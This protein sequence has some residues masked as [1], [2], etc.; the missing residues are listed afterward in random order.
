[1]QRNTWFG[2][3]ASE[4]STE[5]VE[6]SPVRPRASVWMNPIAP[7][8]IKE[9]RNIPNPQTPIP[10]RASARP[11]NVRPRY[12]RNYAMPPESDVTRVPTMPEPTIWQYD[13][14][15]FEAESSLS[16]LSLAHSEAI[17]SRPLA[18]QV[19]LPPPRTH[20]ID[21]LDTQPPPP[22]TAIDE[23]DTRPPA[24][25]RSFAEY[26][27]VPRPR[28]IDELDT[29]PPPS[30][31]NTLIVQKSPV[32]ADKKNISSTHSLREITPFSHT[33]ANMR[34]TPTVIE[35]MLE[36]RLEEAVSWTT[37]V[38]KDSPRARR[39]ASR[40]KEY[41]GQRKS[42]LSLNPVDRVR[43][44]LLYPGRIEFLLWL[45]GTIILFIITCLLLFATV[46][47]VGWLHLGASVSGTQIAAG[48]GPPSS[49]QTPCASDN[50]TN[51]YCHQTTVSSSGLQL[52]LIDNALL[53]PTTP[54]LLH[55][56]GFS[57]NVPV[58]L[59]YDAHQPC[60]PNAT[61]AD[62]HGIFTVSL[63]LGANVS[64][65]T[66]R[67]TAYDTGSKRS[68]E[69]T[70]SIASATNAKSTPSTPTHPSSGATPPA[71]G[72]GSVGGG[73]GSNPTPISQTPVPVKPTVGI[74]PT[75]VVTQ[76]PTPTVSATP[77][78]T[79]G[80]TP[81]IGTTTTPTTTKKENTPALALKN[82]LYDDRTNG[83]TALSPWLWVALIGYLLSMT[84]LGL[85][86]LLSRRTRRSSSR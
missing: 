67:I 7:I 40:A 61:Q 57:A 56:Q 23:L 65:G 11:V 58:V 73:Q 48:G 55:G 59:T 43:W 14:A 69:A 83:Y 47:S 1:M 52:T 75:I 44:W 32:L 6:H 10:A 68:I 27:T 46:L 76:P 72:G 66:H 49:V 4:E 41:K 22:S 38:G 62:A 36:K 33:L 82:A 45:N 51:S 17:M 50:I 81:T 39:I 80:I 53:L 64:S 21:E 74:T 54:I 19:T 20:A 71:T 37:G 79:V 12:P 13:A 60:Y 9:Q 25:E 35:R 78:P 30:K 29:L 18:E 3:S 15:D 2:G 8:G 70:I 5:N 31:Q 63:L 77:H 84:M 86:G 85:A 24:P 42:T 34:P 26:N 28:T 16:S